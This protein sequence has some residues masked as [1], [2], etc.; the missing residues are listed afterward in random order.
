MLR[1]F[2]K[3]TVKRRLGSDILRV[4]AAHMA[5]AGTTFADVSGLVPEGESDI[6]VPPQL[7]QGG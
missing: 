5:L 7:V 4:L 3:E 1:G 2:G 6:G